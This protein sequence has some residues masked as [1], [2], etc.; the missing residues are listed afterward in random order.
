MKFTNLTRTL[1]KL[2][3]ATLITSQLNNSTLKCLEINPQDKKVKRETKLTPFI[4]K[5]DVR[6]LVTSWSTGTTLN[7]NI[8]I[9]YG[10]I[11]SIGNEAYF[12]DKPDSMFKA[13]FVGTRN[14]NRIV[15]AFEKTNPKLKKDE[16]RAYIRGKDPGP[17]SVDYFNKLFCNGKLSEDDLDKY[18]ADGIYGFWYVAKDDKD[19]IL[20]S[21]PGILEIQ[22]EPREK[23]KEDSLETKIDTTKEIIPEE[24]EEEYVQ[25]KDMLSVEYLKQRKLEMDSLYNVLLEKQKSSKIS[26]TEKEDLEEILK[27]REKLSELIEGR[28]KKHPFDVGIGYTFGTSN[29]YNGNFTLRYNIKNFIFGLEAGYGEN[30]KINSDNVVLTPQNTITGFLGEGFERTSEKNLDIY[31]GIETG[32]NLGLI[33]LVL[34][35]GVNVNNLTK[36]KEVEEYIINNVNAIVAK[37]K[38]RYDEGTKTKKALHGFGLDLNLGRVK[39]GGRVIGNGKKY[40]PQLKMF[41]NF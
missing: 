2:F 22:Y 15:E 6:Y 34:D 40:H 20:A 38:D 35:A 28:L 30:S 3:F 36:T 18:L 5:G 4:L 26:P 41:Y 12:E 32:Y 21:L 27:E 9:V 19:S 25:Q 24:L 39:V 13:Y 7:G 31:Y 1:L 23:L 29:N 33:S 14:L 10:P 16:L 17:T 11:E 37:N 8:P